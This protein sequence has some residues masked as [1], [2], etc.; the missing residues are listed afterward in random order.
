M[1]SRGRVRES[2][3]SVPFSR[4]TFHTFSSS[5]AHSLS[6]SLFSLSLDLV[7]GPIT[8]ELCFRCALVPYLLT[9]GLSPL[10]TTFLS[11]FFFGFAHVHHAYNQFNIPIEHRLA[12]QRIVVQT[13]F[14]FAYT[15][16]F[17]AYCC[18]ALIVTGSAA[19]PI[20][21]HVFCNFMGLPDLSFTGPGSRVYVRKRTLFVDSSASSVLIDPF[22][23][24]PPPPSFLSPRCRFK[25]RFVIG[26]AYGVGIV[27]FV[28]GFRYLPVNHSAL[29]ALTK[30]G[31]EI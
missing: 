20:W 31:A 23:S 29:V 17:G 30:V 7:V 11:P 16:L 27:G 18:Y 1:F 21:C 5:Y 22:S 8:E 15:S 25:N 6:L 14:Q 4:Q 24:S 2:E 19:G 28:V 13:V 9:A 3:V 10:A 12:T 26:A